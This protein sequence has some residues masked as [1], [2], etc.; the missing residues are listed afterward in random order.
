MTLKI[1]RGVGGA[2]FRNQLTDDLIED[3]KSAPSSRFFYVV[4]NHI[5]FNSEVSVIDQVAV[6]TDGFE[7]VPQVEVYS[8]TRLAWVLMNRNTKE[9]SDTALNIIV[10]RILENNSNISE[11]FKRGKNKLGFIEQISNQIKELRQSGIDSAQMNIII[12]STDDAFLND[13]LRNLLIILE[14]VNIFIADKY[15]LTGEVLIEFENWLIENKEPISEY[16][17]YVEGFSGFTAAE[18]KVFESLSKIAKVEIGLIGNPNDNQGKNPLFGRVNGLYSRISKFGET[19]STIKSKLKTNS[20][21]D[22][23]EKSWR[24]IET[25]GETSIDNK[26]PLIIAENREAEI[27]EIARTIRKKTLDGQLRYKDILLVA[28]DLSGYQSFIKQ[29]FS[30]FDIPIYIDDDQTLNEHS[31]AEMLM[32]LFDLSDSKPSHFSY[33]KIMRLLKTNLLVNDDDFE[34]TLWH[35]ENYVLAT[36]K[37]N[38][39]NEWSIKKQKGTFDDDAE[40]IIEQDP[41]EPA[42]NNL[43]I[44]AVSVIEDFKKIT[45]Q[46]TISESIRQLYFFIEKYGVLDRMIF[47]KDIQE[48]QKA[49]DIWRIFTNAM[50]EISEIFGEFEFSVD[51]FKNILKTAF[52]GVSFTGVPSTLDELQISEAGSA[53]S[54]DYKLVIYFGMTSS[55]LPAN[56][57]N[58]TFISDVERLIIEKIQMNNFDTELNQLKNTAAAK[59]ADE[60]LLFYQT[61][62]SSTDEIIFSYPLS[63]GQAESFNQ[64]I[65]LER[66]AP[67]PE[68]TI[69]VKNHAENIQELP[70]YLGSFRS[71]LDQFAALNIKNGEPLIEKSPQLVKNV[72]QEYSNKTYKADSKKVRSLIGDALEFSV[73]GLQKYYQNPYEYFLSYVLKLKERNVLQ[74]NVAHEGTYYHAGFEIVTNQLKNDPI[75]KW[76]SQKI[77]EIIEN[78]VNV[79]TIVEMGNPA[80]EILNSSIEYQYVEAEFKNNL[81]IALDRIIK[82][83]QSDQSQKVLEVETKFDNFEKIIDDENTIKLRGRIDRIDHLNNS[84]VI[85][86]YKTNGKKFEFGKF[87]AGV[88]LQLLTYWQEAEK[89]GVDGAFF[90]GVKPEITNLIKVKDDN[91]VFLGHKERVNNIDS[92]F[93]FQGKFNDEKIDFNKEMM[94][95]GNQISN[96]FKNMLFLHN[97]NLIKRAALEILDGKFNILPY[98]ENNDTNGL[99]NSPYT[100]VMRFDVLLGDKYRQ[101]ESNSKAEELLKEGEND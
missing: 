21:A 83:A 61:V 30:R 4:P 15:S 6:K 78:E 48:Q 5:K 74:L 60:S 99:A 66:L 8:L 63:D 64:S 91:F 36:N 90:L 75:Y 81:K 24:E 38:W 31:F 12:D 29:I 68:N 86:D 80:L 35:L 76:N 88:E 18:Q 89:N 100:D 42:I 69:K 9:I 41:E 2:D 92:D 16:H 17:F 59:M 101:I 96:D 34:E 33:L 54:S 7:I 53:Q 44:F 51:Q 57:N 37:T 67:S 20:D 1:Y 52:N 87:Y 40:G 32:S 77:D 56:A 25:V 22:V 46:N 62:L 26:I 23:F 82:M 95:R 55:L 72:L 14:E 71:T 45:K 3:F 97:D 27:E 58:K 39:K 28:R 73:S 47:Q 93:K 50:T 65:Y 85:V 10:E 49:Q 98:R 13:K 70:N 79:D 94:V 84:D 19:F 11:S 43:R